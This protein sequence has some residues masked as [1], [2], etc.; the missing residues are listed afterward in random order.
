M[1]EC[2]YKVLQRM[3][4]AAHKRMGRPPKFPADMVHDLYV[5]IHDKVTAARPHGYEPMYAR[6]W[7]D[8]WIRTWY[9]ESAREWCPDNTRALTKTIVGKQDVPPI[10]GSDDVTLVIKLMENFSPQQRAI[11]NYRF[12]L[13]DGHHKTYGDIGKIFN[14]SGGRIKVITDDLI[15]QLS[16]AVE[17]CYKYPAYIRNWKP[18]DIN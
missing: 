16:R 12:G 4:G 6:K 2:V 10:F 13:E 5:D 18:I 11:I 14:L 8:G 3:I 17:M 9:W 15:Y 7:I 1:A